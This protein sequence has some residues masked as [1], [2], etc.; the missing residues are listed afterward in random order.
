[1]RRRPDGL[2]VVPRGYGPAVSARTRPGRPRGRPGPC[3]GTR[4]GRSPRTPS[5]SRRRVHTGGRPGSM[6][7]RRLQPAPTHSPASAPAQPPQPRSARVVRRAEQ[8]QPAGPGRAAAPALRRRGPAGPPRDGA[9]PCGPGRPP[10]RPPRP[11]GP[12]T[13]PGSRAV[14]AIM[15]VRTGSLGWAAH[16]ARRWAT[17]SRTTRSRS[18]Y[19]ARSSGCARQSH[20]ALRRAAGQGGEVHEQR[21]HFRVPRQDV[22]PVVQEHGRQRRQVV[23]QPGQ[24]WRRSGGGSVGG[25]GA[26]LGQVEEVGAL[27]RWQTQRPGQRVEYVR[28]RPAGRA[29]APGVPRSRR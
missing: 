14:H 24:R 21:R 27:H 2:P 8:Q 22:V 20:I 13:E 10:R 12:R 1:M 11:T 3:L 7:G 15:P 5:V 6:P 26:P 18:A 25:T 19:R 28:R 17:P 16:A 9:S 4:A 29:P 23:H